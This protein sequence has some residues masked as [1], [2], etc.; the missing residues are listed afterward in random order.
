MSN[1]AG[2]LS[3]VRVIELGVWVAGPAAGGI[4]A[5]WGADVIKVEPEAGDPQRSMFA[6]LGVRADLPVPP[7]ELDNRGKR[8]VV[9]DLRD[10]ADMERFHGLLDTADVL[11]SNMRL[12]AL[13]RLGL[14]SETVCERHPHLVYGVITGYGTTGPDR[15]RAGYDIGAYWA[16]SGAAHTIV[17]PGQ[18]PPGLLSGAGD[19]QTGMALAAGVMAKLIERART[20]RGGF[21]STS[22]LRNGM[23]TN[24]WDT[25]IHLRFRKRSA[26][27]HRTA[28]ATPL[29][30]SYMASDD[31]GFWLICLEA[32]RHWPNLIKAIDRSDL[33]EQERFASA[34]SR[35][36]H[37]VDLIAELDATFAARPAA[38][39]TERFDEFD[40]WWAPI[41]S[42]AQML[43]D[44][45]AQPGIV[46]MTA[47]EG[48]REF[49]SV[50]TPVDFEGYELRPGPVPIL[51]E[52][53][54][55]VLDAL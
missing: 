5:D 24:G 27:T 33:G 51:G 53:T 45:Q 47:R 2:P 26:T 18:L 21:V 41:Q 39:W 36:E 12:G 35:L 20:E 16:R 49:R 19:H 11:I 34:K 14:G 37:C 15:D 55:D 42:I 32:S 29:V 46:E 3:G 38:H 10:G 7:F 50:A 9:L 40:V 4:M 43:E 6:S 44:P 30:N 25:A 31:V 13:E 28:S 8:S 54:D 22:L 23:Y 52:H 17:P 48:E 1:A